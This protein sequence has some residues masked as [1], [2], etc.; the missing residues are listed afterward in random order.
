VTPDD[1]TQARLQRMEDHLHSLD[2]TV[3]VLAAVDD[4]NVKKRI[5]DTF[6]GD[7]RM[8]IILRGVQK[9]M[10]QRQIAGALRDRGLPSAE[11]PRVSESLNQLEE[12]QFVLKVPGGTF[13]PNEGWGKFGLE[14]TL[15]KTLKNKKVDDLT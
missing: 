14:K 5:Q 6:G 10:T 13:I 9:K 15:K 7:A 12:K 8:V 2:K 11:Q 3:S 4:G 1:N